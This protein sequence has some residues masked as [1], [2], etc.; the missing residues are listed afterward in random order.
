MDNINLKKREYDLLT[1][2]IINLKI[3]S[4]DEKK[5]ILYSDVIEKIYNLEGFFVKIGAK[6]G[7]SLKKIH[8]TNI[9][10]DLLGNEYWSFNKNN[11]IIYEGEFV[12]YKIEDENDKYYNTIS[13]ELKPGDPNSIEK[14]NAIPIKFYFVP[15]IHRIF[16]PVNSG[17]TP[18]QAM[19]YFDK[20]L[21]NI[22]EKQ[23]FFNVEI[24]KSSEVIDRIYEFQSLKKL[25]ISVSYTN[26]DL[27][28]DAKK[29]VDLLLKEANTNKYKAEFVA[30]K[31]ESLNM[32]S[33]FIKGG[34]ELSKENGDLVASGENEFGN[35]V[36]INTKNKFEEYVLR[37]KKDSNPF[38]SILKQTLK[39]WRL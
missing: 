23:E 9:S 24:A 6:N 31:N 20:A 4:K 12:K 35:K 14:P 29:F 7:L 21:L 36:V 10:T 33:S 8:K 17:V 16:L 22:F 39:N 3:H 28:N 25:E 37:L 2:Y 11:F 18:I 38:I 32:E 13:K 27:G 19:N 34:I 30:E 1:C 5:E 26:D 15:E